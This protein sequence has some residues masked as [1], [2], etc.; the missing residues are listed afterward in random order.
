MTLSPTGGVGPACWFVIAFSKR[1]STIKSRAGSSWRG[2]ALV[3]SDI[4]SERMASAD[5][6]ETSKADS[7]SCS[8]VIVALKPAD[9]SCDCLNSALPVLDGILNA[10]TGCLRAKAAGGILTI[11]YGGRG[12]AILPETFRCNGEAER[13]L[14]PYHPQTGFRPPSFTL[15]SLRC[16]QAGPCETCFPSH[17]HCS[18]RARV[19][20]RESPA[21]R[22]E[23]RYT[24][25]K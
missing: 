21:L 2:K 12:T 3:T 10:Q 9:T 17:S 16:V 8:D 7:L 15:L 18:A 1:N 20:E 14:A 13:G 25:K 6:P 24:V 4:I 22:D 23:R 19:Q 5:F 11:V